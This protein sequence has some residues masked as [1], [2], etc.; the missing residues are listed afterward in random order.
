M[1]IQDREF[2]CVLFWWDETHVFDQLACR[3]AQAE[4]RRKRLD[5]DGNGVVEFGDFLVF[6]SGNGRSE[7]ETGYE[8][9]SDLN[10]NG[11][12]GFVDFI[13]FAA[14]YEEGQMGAD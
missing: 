2:E 5:Y 1:D 4:F 3:Q 10:E 13:N 11:R 8:V 12:I 9:Q 14:Y 7:G 6:A